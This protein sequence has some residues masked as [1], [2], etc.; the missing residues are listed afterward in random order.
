ML[1]SLN[2]DIAKPLSRPDELNPPPEPKRNT[3]FHSVTRCIS[4]HQNMKC[5]RL[6]SEVVLFDTQFPLF[7]KTL[8][9]RSLITD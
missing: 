9:V 6:T 2:S 5:F 4:E 8:P 7:N 3:A 1:E